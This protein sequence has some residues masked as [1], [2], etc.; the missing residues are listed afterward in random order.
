MVTYKSKTR[1]EN[2][3]KIHQKSE[4]QHPIKAN[5]NTNYIGVYLFAFLLLFG[6]IFL[7]I[8]NMSGGKKSPIIFDDDGNASLAPHRQGKLQKELAEI[9]RAVQYS[10]RAEIDGLFP[11]KTCPNGSNFIHLFKGEVWKIG[12]TRK[13]E[14]GRY[15]GGNYG[16]PNL[17]FLVEYEGTYSE[18]LKMEKM[19]IY[20][21]PLLPEA[22][23]RYFTLAIP[24]GNEID[25]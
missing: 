4:N 12:V 1:K 11:C 3:S 2:H 5:K 18:C 22:L 10:L 23:K 15:P 7:S 6:G 21:Y 25:N 20:N 8:Q 9:D 19:K 16:A 14:K 13:G 17:L 24:P